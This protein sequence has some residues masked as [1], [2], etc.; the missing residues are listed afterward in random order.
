MEASGQLTFQLL[1]PRAPLIVNERKLSW[2]RNRSKSIQHNNSFF[3]NIYSQCPVVSLKVQ[4]H[5]PALPQIGQ[6][7]WDQ[8]FVDA[9]NNVD[10]CMYVYTY[11]YI[12][13]YISRVIQGES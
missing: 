12:Y 1:Y 13:T 10:V 8:I 5:V 7:S 6:I 11:I 4:S 2:G 9:G 3:F